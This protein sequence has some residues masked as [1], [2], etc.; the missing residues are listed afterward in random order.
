ML[1]C[2]FAI[3]DQLNPEGI[4]ARKFSES[5]LHKIRDFNCSCTSIGYGMVSVVLKPT[6][7]HLESKIRFPVVPNMDLCLTEEKRFYQHQWS[8]VLKYFV[9]KRNGERIKNSTKVAYLVHLESEDHKKVQ[10]IF[11]SGIHAFTCTSC[12]TWW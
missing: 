12:S 6:G 11:I 10:P 4:E 3:I 9:S 1:C 2:N 5:I 7:S 8:I